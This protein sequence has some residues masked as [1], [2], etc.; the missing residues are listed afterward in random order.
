MQQLAPG[1]C[2]EVRQGYVEADSSCRCSPE[3]CANCRSDHGLQEHAQVSPQ[4][5]YRQLNLFPGSKNTRRIL[6]RMHLQGKAKLVLIA[7]NTS[8]LRKSELEYY[9][10]LSKTNV[11]HFSGNNVCIRPAFCLFR[12]SALLPHVPCPSLQ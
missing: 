4:R 6:T 10:M 7:S 9:S 3:Q 5:A 1:A 2:D 12:L 8:P 11:H